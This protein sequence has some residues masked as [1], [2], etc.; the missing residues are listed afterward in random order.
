[1]NLFNL[2]AKLGLDSSEFKKGLED[3]KKNASNFASKAGT[4]MKGAAKAFTAVTA[5]VGAV[6]SA[7]V[8]L[9]VKMVDLGGEIDDNAQ[10]LGL[11]TEQYQLWS[12][13]MT[14][15]GTDVTAL[16]RGMI[17]L[18]TWTEELSQ[19]QADALKTLDDLGIGY[20]EFMALDNAGQLETITNALQG[21]ENQ[22]EKARLAQELFGNRVGQ[23][24]MPLFNE[25]QGSIEK[26]NETLREQGVI[27][28]N[29]NIQA[30][31]KLGDKIDL[32]KSTFTSF[33]LKLATDVFP[34]IG[35][36]IDGFQELAT[37]S[38]NASQTIATSLTGVVDKVVGMLPDFIDGVV[39]LL[40]NLLDGIIPIIPDLAVKLFDILANLLDRLVDYV[41]QLLDMAF[42]IIVDLINKLVDYIPTL[43]DMLIDIIVDVVEATIKIFPELMNSIGELIISLIDSLFSEDN[44]GKLIDLLITFVLASAEFLIMQ[45]PDIVFKVGEALFNAIGGLF[46]SENLRRFGNLAVNLG[47]AIVNGIIRGLN[48]LAHIRIPGFRIGNW[49]VWDDV[50]VTL[51]NIPQIAY[52][53]YAQGGMFEDLFGL[54][55]GTA[56]AIAGEEGAEIVAQGRQGTGVANVEQIAEAVEIGQEPTVL[57]IRQAVGDIVNGIVGGM[58]M[59]DRN[60][61]E[62]SITVQIGEKDFKSYIVKTVNET[63]NARGRKNLNAITAY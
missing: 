14:K 43:S 6:A 57:A 4:V 61:G 34:E 9:G 42:G 1:M 44:L 29:E 2:V 28:G 58:S 53:K 21:M 39:N 24:L 59:R 11:S 51:F 26:L 22:T 55:K 46:S 45:L 15:A 19:G 32:L 16:Q 5:T 25:E 41:P 38:E 49:Q 13:A 10:R 52:K 56:Y 30:A 20:E 35:Q 50:D 7:V 12:F 48:N 3:S 33:G 62:A 8:A 54:A 63:L 23:Q 40:F 18:S 47:I 60:S 27:V 37:G 36:L 17:Q 31:A